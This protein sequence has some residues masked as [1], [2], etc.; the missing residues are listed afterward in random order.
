MRLNANNEPVLVIKPSYHRPEMLRESSGHIRLVRDWMGTTEDETYS[1][2]PSKIT[3]PMMAQVRS[4]QD[5]L[6]VKE[7]RQAG[8]TMNSPS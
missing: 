8:S 5:T 6:S 1:M 3:L 2:R 4:R 7:K